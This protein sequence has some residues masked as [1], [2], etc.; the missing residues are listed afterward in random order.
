MGQ[1][2]EGGLRGWGRVE[3][4][5]RKGKRR[6]PNGQYIPTPLIHRSNPD[7]RKAFE[8]LPPHIQE[9]AKSRHRLLELDPGAL[10]LN[11]WNPFDIVWRVE[12]GEGYR[13]IGAMY[14]RGVIVWLWIGPHDDYEAL[15]DSLRD[16]L[17]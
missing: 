12:V 14:E 17:E 3:D 11:L 5:G 10:K 6:L 2:N 16:H 13:A 9:Q 8:K 15:L 4:A 1:E 7:F